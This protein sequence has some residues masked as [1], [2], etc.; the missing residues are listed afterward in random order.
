MALEANEYSTL[1]EKVI[2]KISAELSK[3][4]RI[5]ELEAYLKKIDCIDLLETYNQYF[6]TRNAKIIIIGDAKITKKDMEVIAKRN[7]IHPDR[8]EFHLDYEKN[9]HFDMRKLKHNFNYSDIIMGP[10]AHSVVGTE[11]YSSIVA[12][13]EHNPSEFPKLNKAIANNELKI[14]KASFEECIRNTQLYLM[15]NG[16]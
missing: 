5:N 9:K 14:T 4:N 3:A 2:R 6:D 12:M 1:Q 8:L 7:G 11:G 15:K 13:I 10:V 16:Y